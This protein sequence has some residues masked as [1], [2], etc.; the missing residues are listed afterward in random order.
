MSKTIPMGCGLDWRQKRKQAP[1]SIS[2]R[3][4][5]EDAMWAAASHFCCHAFPTNYEPKLTF[6]KLLWSDILSREINKLHRVWESD[7]NQEV[8]QVWPTTR[9]QLDRGGVTLQTCKVAW[10]IR[11][12]S[13][14]GSCDL[15]QYPKPL[16]AYEESKESSGIPG[17]ASSSLFGK[18]GL[19]R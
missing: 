10:S 18:T 4:P 17:M 15:P 12:H 5:T 2:L 7:V 14:Y 16:F 11:W 3:F 6:L 1:A 9:S 8:G 19:G 13:F